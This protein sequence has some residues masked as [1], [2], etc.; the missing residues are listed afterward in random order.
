[1]FNEVIKQSVDAVS[2]LAKP[3]LGLCSTA[4]DLGGEFTD[5]FVAKGVHNVRQHIGL[6][7]ALS[8]D[9]VPEQLA[10]EAIIANYKRLRETMIDLNSRLV[11]RLS[12]YALREGASRLGILQDGVFCFN[13]EQESS[14]LMDYCLYNVKENGKNAIERYLLD[15]PPAWDSC[16]WTCLRAMQLAKYVILIVESTEPGYCLHARSLMTDQRLMLVDLN[17]SQCVDPGFILA[18]RVLDFDKYCTS[19]GV[20]LPLGKMAKNSPIDLDTFQGLSRSLTRP[21]K[22]GN[23]D[24]ASLI[25]AFLERGGASSIRYAQVGED[26]RTSWGQSPQGARERNSRNASCPC[27][28]GKKYKICCAKRR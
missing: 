18:A 1:M 28:S 3:A 27:G 24:P 26:K 23:I 11:S 14:I 15:M 8:H 25:R 22:N 16:E 4:L 13:S 12:K 17:L 7:S 2:I 10:R 20:A 5:I 6:P 19:S 21:D 9:D